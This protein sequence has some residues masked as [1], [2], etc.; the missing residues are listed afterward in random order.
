MNVMVYNTSV[1]VFHIC[2]CVPGSSVDVHG[3]KMDGHMSCSVLHFTEGDTIFFKPI[4]A[5]SCHP[6]PTL[7]PKGVLGDDVTSC[8]EQEPL[9]SSGSELPADNLLFPLRVS[10]CSLTNALFCSTGRRFYTQFC[11]T[12]AKYQLIKHCTVT[13]NMH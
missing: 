3:H 9:C 1:S 8:L 7:H 13:H 4:S 11:H 10:Q 2:L 6:H 5:P 12:H